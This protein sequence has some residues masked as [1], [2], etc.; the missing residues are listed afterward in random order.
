MQNSQLNGMFKQYYLTQ[1]HFIPNE[2][3]QEI[4]LNVWIKIESEISEQIE[5]NVWILKRFKGQLIP[6]N[7]LSLLLN[8]MH[9]YIKNIVI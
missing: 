4:Q 9:V 5:L 1:N 3:I 8:R 6:K 7:A 2:K